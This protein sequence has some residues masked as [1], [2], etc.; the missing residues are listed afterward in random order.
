MI[1]EELTYTQAYSMLQEIISR[2]ENGDLQVDELSENI[3]TA[4]ELMK[5]CKQKLTTIET[6]VDK[7]IKEI[8]KSV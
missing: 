7:L 5:I 1:T 8:E 2:M 6:D 3:R 4:N